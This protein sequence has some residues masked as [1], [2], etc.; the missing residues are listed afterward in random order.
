[1][2]DTFNGHSWDSHGVYAAQRGDSWDLLAN[3]FYEGNSLLAP[4]LTYANPEH[5]DILLFEGGE[6]VMIPVIR[7][8]TSLLLPPWTRPTRGMVHADIV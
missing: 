6:S 3:L 4:L 8:D 2:P 5:A 7:R 1:M